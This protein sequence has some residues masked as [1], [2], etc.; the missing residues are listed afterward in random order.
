VGEYRHEGGANDRLASHRV[1]ADIAHERGLSVE[2]KNDLPHISPL[3][4]DSRRLK[5]P[6]MV[7]RPEL[8]V[9]R[10]PC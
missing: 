10:E 4:A 8:G 1:I 7:K 3:C 5:L 2:L 9:W 6:S